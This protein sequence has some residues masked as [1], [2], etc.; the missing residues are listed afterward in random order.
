MAKS[1]A[2]S[3]K[4]Q[5]L[6]Q[7]V[8]PVKRPLLLAWALSALATLALI[9]QC[10]ALASVFANLLMAVHHGLAQNSGQIL[11]ADNAVWLGMLAI[12]MLLRVLLHTVRQWLAQN[13]GWQVAANLR[14]RIMQRLA[15]LGNERTRFGSDGSLASQVINQTD[16]L[17]DYVSR[18]YI[19]RYVVAS[20]PLLLL[21]AAATQSLVATGVM[22]L[23]APLVPIFMI[24][25]GSATAKKSAE[26]FAALAQLGGRFL[27]W[28]RG[29]PTLQRL[30]ATQQARTDI[31]AAAEAYRNRT[32]A[33]LKI[34]F[35]N[36]AALELLSAL[37]IALLA[38]YLG[39][40]LLGLL[41]WQKGVVPVDYHA[42]LFLLLL[43][44][45][46]YAPLR[47]LGA[48]YHIKAQAE[49]AL[50]S[51]LPL[52]DDKTTSVHATANALHNPPNATPPTLILD[53]VT[54]QMADG[55]TR[56]APLSLTIAARQRVAVIGASG[57]GKST[58]LQILL[59]F[60]Q[61]TGQIT[62]K[63][64]AENATDAADD[65]P[66]NLNSLN[67]TTL[68]KD[69]WRAQVAYLSQNTSLLPMSIADNLRLVKPHAS[70]DELQTVLQAVELWELIARL[71]QG[72]ATP[73]A[74]HGRGLSGGQLRRLAIAQLLLQDAPLWLLDE[75]TEHLD[76]ETAT[77]INSLLARITYG[78][79]VLWV[80]HQPERL[81][82]LDGVMT[83]AAPSVHAVV[84]V[85]D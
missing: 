5:L 51:L 62:V 38:V 15:Q 61:Y 74:E 42:A 80:S 34:A 64:Q 39:L 33:V 69:A 41:P 2:L 59:G 55:R 12:C 72:L 24:L 50:D 83:L 21:L 70:D 14:Q 7:L 28:L 19:Q 37:A 35:L 20:T 23:T 8:Q 36:S 17:A 10:Y 75:P 45:E 43:A 3:P 52:L 67:F 31:A 85:E 54:C 25:I 65:G 63:W 56:L 66:L 53:D 11:L 9:G 22:L 58:L 47:Q 32:M 79:T 1:R 49:G 73:L 77:H 4:Q 68:N 27:D 60:C 16:A 6:R 18:F 82:S 76:P 26:Q 13:A 81:P 30:S 71:P 84:K 57:S 44:P 46:F 29:M 48:D 40:G 78:K